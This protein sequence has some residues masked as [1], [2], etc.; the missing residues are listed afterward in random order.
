MKSICEGLPPGVYHGIPA[1][2]Y[3]ALDAVSNS[4][5]SRLR[6]SPELCK[7]YMT[8]EREQ[9]NAMRIGT[10]VHTEALEQ[11]LFDLNYATMPDFKPIKEGSKVVKTIKAQEA[12]FEALHP[13]K[14]F[15]SHNE[16]R[17]IKAQGKSIREHKLAKHFISNLKTEITILFNRDGI[18]CKCRLD[19]YNE[20][21]KTIIDIKT[22]VSAS[23]R[24][25]EKSIFTYGYHRQAAMYL[26]AAKAAGLEAN[27]FVFIAIEKKAP[28]QVGVYRMKDDVI[29]LA[30]KEINELLS[31][32]KDCVKADYWPG[33]TEKI[34]DI[35]I[36]SWAVNETNDFIEGE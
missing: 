20:K 4:R 13:G 22:T 30:D 21:L 26:A 23:P 35:G 3:H 33:Y 24:S 17:D 9:T 10:A 25:F 18:D 7:Y 1:A 8:N 34:V 14:T 11:E 29:A 28:Y 5:L 36:P 27:H 6:Q 19:G 31:L 2:D 15:L 16:F 32:Y 12:E